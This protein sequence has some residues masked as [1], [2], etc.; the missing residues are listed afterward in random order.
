MMPVRFATTIVVPVSRNGTLKSETGQ[1]SHKV[2]ALEV[3]MSSG[4]Q[5]EFIDGMSVMYMK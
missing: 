3:P 5:L 2:H 1:T 4:S